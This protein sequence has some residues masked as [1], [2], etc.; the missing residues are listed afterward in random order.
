VIELTEAQAQA[1][2]KAGEAPTEVVDPRTNTA[3]VLLRREAYEK[4]T[5]QY[6]DGP[7]TAEERDALALEAGQSLGWDDMDEYDHP[8]RN[9]R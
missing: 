7:W 3:Y 6:D 4:L 9:R 1:A 2:E 8:D 5:A